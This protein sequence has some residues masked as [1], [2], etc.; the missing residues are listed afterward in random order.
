MIN[1]FYL[2]N[3][4]SFWSTILVH[5]L[6]SI[7]SL[8]PYKQWVEQDPSHQ[9]KL[10]GKVKQAYDRPGTVKCIAVPQ[11]LNEADIGQGR[12][13]TSL[14]CQRFQA[15]TVVSLNWTSLNGRSL[16]IMLTVLFSLSCLPQIKQTVFK[17][18][19]HGYLILTIDQTKLLSEPYFES[20]MQL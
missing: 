19:K 20:D 16:E 12:A 1:S 11:K 6:S 9:T 10:V 7:H 18:Q 2:V 3:P 14:I 17:K 15:G 13:I 5:V 8:I 4:S